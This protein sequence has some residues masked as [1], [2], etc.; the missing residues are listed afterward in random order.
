MNNCTQNYDKPINVQKGYWLGFDRSNTYYLLLLQKQ[1]S[2]K[3]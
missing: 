3:V 1:E 2:V